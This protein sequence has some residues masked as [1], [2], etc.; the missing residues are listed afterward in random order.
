MVFVPSDVKTARSKWNDL[1]KSK[2]HN[3]RNLLNK[4]EIEIF[5]SLLKIGKVKLINFSFSRSEINE[6]VNRLMKEVKELEKKHHPESV[7]LSGDEA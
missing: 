7:Q 3:Q 4:K 2:H 6:M 5:K 1:F